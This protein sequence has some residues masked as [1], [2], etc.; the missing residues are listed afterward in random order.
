MGNVLFPLLTCGDIKQ[1]YRR[2]DWTEN[3]KYGMKSK[4][5]SGL[6]S[7]FLISVVKRSSYS[8]QRIENR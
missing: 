4:D 5:K 6:L 1:R 2:Q 3:L 7:K 8:Y